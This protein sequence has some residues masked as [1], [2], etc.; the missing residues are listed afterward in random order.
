[1][2]ARYFSRLND[3]RGMDESRANGSQPRRGRDERGWIAKRENGAGKRQQWRGFWRRRRGELCRCFEMLQAA[4]VRGVVLAPLPYLQPERLLTGLSIG[5]AVTLV[6]RRLLSTFRSCSCCT[7][8]GPVTPLRC[9]VSRQL[10][11][12]AAVF[13]SYAPARRATRVDPIMALHYE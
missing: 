8:Y 4:V 2:L 10:L 6:L 5:M 13:A 9:S 11:I 3:Y 12:A 7:A 1:M